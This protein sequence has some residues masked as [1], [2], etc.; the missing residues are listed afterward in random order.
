MVNHPPG[1]TGVKR[2]ELKTTEND[3]VVRMKRF[4]QDDSGVVLVAVLGA[5]ALL[6]AMSIGAYTLSAQALQETEMA[7]GRQG[8]F[9]AADAG[10]SIALGKVQERIAAGQTGALST[11]GVINGSTYNVTVAPVTGSLI[12]YSMVSYG[13]SADGVRETIVA[14]I[15]ILPARPAPLGPWGFMLTNGSFNNNQTWNGGVHGKLAIRYPQG[16]LG[17]ALLGNSNNANSDIGWASADVYLWN[18]QKITWGKVNQ[19]GNTVVPIHSNRLP[20]VQDGWKVLGATPVQ[21]L[22]DAPALPVMNYPDYATG[23]VW[24]HSGD[25]TFG[26]VNEGTSGSAFFYNGTTGVLTLNGTIYVDGAVIFS[27]PKSATKITYVGNGTIAT[28]DGHQIE[29][30]IDVVPATTGNVLDPTHVMGFTTNTFIKCFA[31]CTIASGAFYAGQ[32]I[33]VPTPGKIVG[34]V[35][36]GA[37][38]PGTGNPWGIVAYDPSKV[39][40]GELPDLILDDLDWAT[41]LPAGMPRTSGMSGSMQPATAI[42]LNWR[43]M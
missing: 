32:Y 42:M 28:A 38:A 22:P 35:I 40:K 34:T 15:T 27:K 8:A 13:L 29:M 19:S 16:T 33:T 4:A 24:T 39:K 12:D 21:D 23:A 5:V 1:R 3:E 43:R 37:A 2:S 26:E 36:A 10:A 6:T 11:T 9:S 20:V 31:P 25:V 18:A 17:T 14:S 7:E 41:Y 30:K